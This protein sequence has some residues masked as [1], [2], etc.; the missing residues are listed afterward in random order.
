MLL[1]FLSGERPW[2]CEH[3]AKAFLH[4]ETYRAHVRRHTGEKPFS[5]ELCNKAFTENWALKKHQRIHTGERP[6]KC[7]HCGKAFADSSNLAKHCKAH[8]KAGD[9]VTAKD[10]TVWNIIN[11]AAATSNSE[12]DDVQQIIYI[13]YDDDGMAKETAVHIVSQT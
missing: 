5:C 12:Q 10:G 2:Q 8:A 3:C 7:E 9:E 11:H 4:K 6:Y 13:A 1:K